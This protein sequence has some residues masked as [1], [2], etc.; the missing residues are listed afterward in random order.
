M[1]IVFA[2]EAEIIEWRTLEAISLSESNIKKKYEQ[3]LVDVTLKH[4]K[5][6]Y[7]SE[8]VR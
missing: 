7:Y 3:A 2:K 4:K 6:K 1:F 8:V 5:R